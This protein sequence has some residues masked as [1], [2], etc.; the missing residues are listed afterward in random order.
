MR[1]VNGDAAEEQAAALDEGPTEPGGLP[2][3]A[4]RRDERVRRLVVLGSVGLQVQAGLARHVG[5]LA[6]C[7]AS[8]AAER[9]RLAGA[10]GQDEPRTAEPGVRSERAELPDAK[11]RLLAVPGSVG[12]QVQGGWARHVGRL[13][14]CAASPA[15]ALLA[16]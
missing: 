16:V 5:R 3:W 7:A 6:S 9:P 11:G 8:P 4:A 1:S 12:L 10:T 2:G 14:S 13:T 15:A